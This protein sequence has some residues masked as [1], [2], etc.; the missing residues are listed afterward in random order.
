M[1]MVYVARKQCANF[2][3]L[4]G[5][6]CNLSFSIVSQATNLPPIVRIY[7]AGLLTLTAGGLYIVPVV[8]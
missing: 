6:V 4:G 3:D 1:R 8:S 7:G 5:E 2:V